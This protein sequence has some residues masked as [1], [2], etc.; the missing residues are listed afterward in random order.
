M[1]ITRIIIIALFITCFTV[2]GFAQPNFGGNN[3]SFTP[4]DAEPTP[5]SGLVFLGIA[6]GAVIGY[7]KLK[8]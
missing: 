7:K 3:G 6:A 4:N 5:L 1:K 8:D 2:I